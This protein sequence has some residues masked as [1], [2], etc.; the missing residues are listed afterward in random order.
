MADFHFCSNSGDAIGGS[1]RTVDG[2]DEGDAAAAFEAVAGRRA[3]LADGLEEIFENSLMA[4]EVSHSGGRGAFVFVERGV[5]GGS[6]SVA[7][8]GG[9][10]AV[11]LEDDGAFGAGDFDAARVARIRGGGGMENAEGAAG[12]FQDGGGGVF[13]LDLVKKRAGTGLYAN[14]VTEQ[15]E[16]QVNGVD[17]L[18]DQGAAA[19]ERVGAT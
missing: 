8:M 15:P 10:D 1:C 14:D 6:A 9:D 2:F 13:G 7:E 4:A 3:I 5:L 11:V 12:K 18:I 16:K 19:V 17:A